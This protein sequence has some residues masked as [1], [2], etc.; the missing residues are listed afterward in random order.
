MITMRGKG[1]GK[2]MYG[3]LVNKSGTHWFEWESRN[4]A[5]SH[6]FRSY[7][8]RVYFRLCLR[9]QIGGIRYED[10][11]ETIF[12]STGFVMSKGHFLCARVTFVQLVA[13]TYLFSCSKRY[14][15]RTL[16]R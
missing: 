5:Y 11:D 15:M 3:S 1:D 6:N 9:L 8:Q 10:E 13:N 7:P 12:D 4:D 14:L 16:R 2:G